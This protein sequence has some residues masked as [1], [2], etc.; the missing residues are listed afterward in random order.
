MDLFGK[1]ETMTAK[2]R[3]ELN[4]LRRKEKC[5]PLDDEELDRLYELEDKE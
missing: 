1:E 3:K 2:E 5:C 4:Y